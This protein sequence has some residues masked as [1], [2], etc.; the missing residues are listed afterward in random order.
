MNDERPGTPTAP[1]AID[2]D[3]ISETIR[4]ALRF[5]AT[6]PA[7][8]VLAGADAVLR[9]HVG[10]LL[11]DVREAASRQPHSFETLRLTKRMDRIEQ[12]LAHPFG[13]GVLP[14]RAEV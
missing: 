13:Q 3:T 14:P 6:R 2:A 7:R 1:D 5:G 9:G 8:D 12:Q 4:R 11:D 10:L